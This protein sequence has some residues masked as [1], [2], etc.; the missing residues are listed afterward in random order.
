MR[1]FSLRIF[2]ASLLSFYTICLAGCDASPNTQVRSGNSKD[3]YIEEELS[4]T[5]KK[6]APYLEASN[7]YLGQLT[8]GDYQQ[9]VKDFH[10]DYK[11]VAS[12]EAFKSAFAPVLRMQG[13][14]KSYKPMQWWFIQTKAS[15][16]NIIISRKIVEHEFGFI[17]YKFMFYSDDPEKKLVGLSMNT[18]NPQT[19]MFLVPHHNL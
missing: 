18:Y 4:A 12:E 11:S 2:I 10:S 16:K 17:V 3:A 19:D 6:Y 1:A 7:M 15:G 8:K 13:S 14:Y 9:V 5:S